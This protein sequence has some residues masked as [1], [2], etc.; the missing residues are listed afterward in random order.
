MQE[1][2]NS[3]LVRPVQ[4]SQEKTQDACEKRISMNCQSLFHGSDQA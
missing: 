2:A 4:A 3:H 1:E